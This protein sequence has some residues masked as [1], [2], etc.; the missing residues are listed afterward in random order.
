M[1]LKYA[2]CILIVAAASGYGYYRG[3][4]YKRQAGEMRYQVQ[5]IREISGE[6]AYSKAPLAEIFGHMAKRSRP[7]YNIWLHN[8][9]E[10]LKERGTSQF[11][12]LWKEKTGELLNDLGFDEEE[13]ELLKELG[14]RMDHLDIRM[15]EETLRRYAGG[16][17]ERCVRK[18]NDLREKQR[19]CSL[20]GAAAGVFLAILLL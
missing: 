11:A 16:L 5:L 6:I 4:E 18:E 20:L 3:M 10:V 2:G 14:E 9:A 17:E 15:Q 13:E 8:M 7:P 1:L 19:L 12:K